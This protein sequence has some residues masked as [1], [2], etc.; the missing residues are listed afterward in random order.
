M[1]IFPQSDLQFGFKPKISTSHAIFTL[2]KTVD[3]FVCNKSRAFLAFLDCS[4]AFDKISHWGLFIKLVKRGVPLCFVLSII[5]LYLNMSCLVKW[6]NQM[7]NAFEVPTGTKQGGVLSPNLFSFYMHDL[8]EL[9]KKSGYGC[10]VIEV[11]VSCI[12]FADDVVLMSPS[13]FGLQRLLDIC[14]SY[15]K[16][17]CLDF[18]AKKS[19]IMVIGKALNTDLSPLSLNDLSLEFVSEYKYLGVTFHAAKQLSFSSTAVI[20]SFHRAANAILFSRVKPDRNVLMKLLYANCVPILTYACEV[21]EFS[22][23]EMYRC[24]VAVNNAIRKIYSYAV[25]QSIRHIRISSGYKSIYEIFSLAKT[26]F[27]DA[28]KSCSNQ[29]V[30]HL[31]KKLPC[32]L[33]P[34]A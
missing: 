11:C 15:C 5:Y 7:S 10:H 1:V 32:D 19:K 23:S 28:A 26:K 9:L 17:Y 6:K 29:V 34:V 8:I 24:H 33:T 4:K 14:V 3:Y 30:M 22:A 16:K 31:V 20:H 27:L 13:R 18:N 12:F 25:W 21:R 2:K